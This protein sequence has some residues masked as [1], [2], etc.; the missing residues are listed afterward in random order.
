MKKNLQAIQVKYD[1]LW[2]M[3]LLTIRYSMGRR[4]YMPEY[5]IELYQN[6]GRKLSDG[7]KRQIADEIRRE[8]DLVEGCLKTLGAQCDHETWLTLEEVIKKDLN[9]Q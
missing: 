8:L 4:T 7:C 1:D 3:L 2:T 6:Y 5:C 9:E